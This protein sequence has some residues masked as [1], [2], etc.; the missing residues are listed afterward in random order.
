MRWDGFDSNDVPSALSEQQ[1]HFPNGPVGVRQFQRRCEMRNVIIATICAAA[2]GALSL[3]TASAQMTGPSG[4]DST[5]MGTKD[6]MK[7]DSNTQGMSKDSMSKDG[8]TKD[9]MSKDGTK[10]DT[11][12]KDGMKK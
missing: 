9:S 11:M 3:G 8:M 12:S 5:K 2:I 6:G 7:K 4:Q 10:T 1:E